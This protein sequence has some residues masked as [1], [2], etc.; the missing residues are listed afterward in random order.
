MAINVSLANS[1]ASTLLSYYDALN[2][3]NNIINSMQVT[4]DYDWQS[5]EVTY[6]N[7]IIVSTSNAMTGLMNW[8]QALSSDIVTIANEISNEEAAAAAAAA[9]SAK[10]T[11]SAT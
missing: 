1:Q 2:S 3:I 7:S 6:L 11:A 9:A 5:D 4:T 8:I 10:A